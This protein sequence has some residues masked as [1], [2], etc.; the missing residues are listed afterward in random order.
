MELGEAGLTATL[1]L[2]VE[3]PHAKER[4]WPWRPEEAG[5]RSSQSFQREAPL[6]MPGFQ[7]SET[8]AGI[9]TSRAVRVITLY[10]FHFKPPRW[11]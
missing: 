9:L 8:S 10:G 3:G 11:R 5:R 2:K 7:F 4:G 6:L 1:A